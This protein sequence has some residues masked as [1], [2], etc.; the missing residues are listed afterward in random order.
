MA[1]AEGAILL[2][3]QDQ[4]MQM[5]EQDESFKGMSEKGAIRYGG[6]AEYLSDWINSFV[7]WDSRHLALGHL[8]RGGSPTA[9][10]RVLAFSLGAQCAKLIDEKNYQQVVGFHQ[11]KVHHMSFDEV[12]T[13]NQEQQKPLPEE[14]YKLCQIASKG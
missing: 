2:D 7:D 13:N 10:D 8:Q 12:Y 14:F 11:G 9:M 4:P 1:V 5:F 6:I 3:D